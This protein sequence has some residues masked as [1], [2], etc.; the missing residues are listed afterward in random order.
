MAKQP[1]PQAEA[2]AE[3][4]KGIEVVSN[5]GFVIEDNTDVAPVEPPVVE[6]EEIE[7]IDGIVQVNYK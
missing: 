3:A 2:P 1:T 7:L 4:P 5:D 6:A